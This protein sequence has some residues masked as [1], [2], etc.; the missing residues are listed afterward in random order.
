MCTVKLW[1]PM[2]KGMTKIKSHIWKW[3]YPKSLL[4]NIVSILR[5]ILR[6]HHY[7]T[8]KPI[9][10]SAI[11]KAVISNYPRVFSVIIYT[12]FS[13][14]KLEDLKSPNSNQFLSFSFQL[15]LKNKN[16]LSFLMVVSQKA[17]CKYSDGWSQW[18]Q[19]ATDKEKVV[20]LSHHGYYRLPPISLKVIS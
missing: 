11:S 3:H 6:V 12:K 16:F 20:I 14:N 18:R 2:R 19:I 7:K 8:I 1:L 9:H 15:N 10:I 13:Y 17:L 4:P 5:F